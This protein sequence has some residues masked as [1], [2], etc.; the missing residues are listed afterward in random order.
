MHCILLKYMQKKRNCRII[1]M[2]MQMVILIINRKL[3][4]TKDLQLLFLVYNTNGVAAYYRDS[5]LQ[6]KLARASWSSSD[7]R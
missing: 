3:R 2:I 5:E 7:P 4:G 6:T 1:K